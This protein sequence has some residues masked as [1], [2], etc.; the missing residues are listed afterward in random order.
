MNS[1]KLHQHCPYSVLHQVYSLT[2]SECYVKVPA[3]GVLPLSSAR[4]DNMYDREDGTCHSTVHLQFAMSQCCPPWFSGISCCLM[5][6]NARNH[7]IEAECIQRC[8]PLM[9]PNLDEEAVW[10]LPDWLLD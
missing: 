7:E 1:T 6:Q 2:A 4:R 5:A 9:S 8:A 3:V 10:C